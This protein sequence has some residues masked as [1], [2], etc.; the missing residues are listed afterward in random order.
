MSGPAIDERDDRIWLDKAAQLAERGVGLTRPNPP[1]GAVVVQ[2]GVSVGQGLHLRAGGAHAEVG[3]LREAGTRSRGATLYVTLEPCSTQGRTPPCTE[4]IVA[5]GI[6]RVVIGALDPN[7][8][9]AGRAR[10]WLRRRGVAVRVLPHAPSRA[11]IEP[12]GSVMTRGRP[13]VTL[14]LGMTLD[15]RIAD[16]RGVSQWITGTAARAEVQALRRRADAIL[17][18]AGTVRAD[19]P[20]LWP[21]PARGR[22]PWRVVVAGQQR[23]PADAKLFTDAHADRT[24]VATP[25]KYPATWRQRLL[26]NGAQWLSIP[27]RPTA[28]LQSL[29]N[30]LATRDVLHVLCEGGSEL[31]GGLMRA[32]LV[33]ELVIFMAP[34]LLGAQ[35]IPAFAG[36]GWSL[37]TMP[38]LRVFEVR[39]VGEDVLVRA[40][41]AGAGIV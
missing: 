21:R 3:A 2:D 19:N 37:A 14:K 35:G 22:S 29:L 16:A 41:P 39:S 5:A 10:G 12:F 13:W 17:V 26:R 9:H 25:A 33:D 28:G 4:A 27:A 11:L 1:V 31:A 40:R 36:T 6:R 8:K 23:L 7:P 30:Q 18:G 20:S 38:E 34:R 32:G 15:G 24:L